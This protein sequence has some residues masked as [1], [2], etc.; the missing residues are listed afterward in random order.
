M[1]E[2]SNKNLTVY[3]K[4]LRNEMTRE[5]KHLWYD[6]LK[7]LPFDVKRQKV[8]GKYIVDFYI[9]K[10]KI[11]I[12]L[13]GIQHYTEEHIEIDTERDEYMR[14]KEMLVLRYPNSDINKRF[15]YVC[16]D[17]VMKIKEKND[18]VQ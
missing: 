15:E 11:I 13:D 9:P 5:E 17:I 2:L 3:S 12:E 14:S 16:A 8:I 10:Y 4:K 7:K 1:N 6:F 18:T